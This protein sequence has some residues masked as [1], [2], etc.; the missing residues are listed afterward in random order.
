M[1]KSRVKG[2][3]ALDLHA[4]EGMNGLFRVLLGMRMT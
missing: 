1:F 2:I 3:A 4:D